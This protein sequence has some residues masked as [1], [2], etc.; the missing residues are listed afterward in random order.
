MPFNPKH[1]FAMVQEYS[2]IF[3]HGDQYVGALGALVTIFTTE[4]RP[5]FLGAAS[6]RFCTC[7]PRFYLL[8]RQVANL[9]RFSSSSADATG[10]F[11]NIQEYFT[12]V[13]NMCTATHPVP[14]W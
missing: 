1:N 11:R 6:R 2:G 8:A 12:M 13:S 10:I 4:S 3:H 14:T 5:L 7:A 9:N